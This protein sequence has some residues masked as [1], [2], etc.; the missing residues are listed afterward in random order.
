MPKERLDSLLVARGL[1]ENRSRAQ[2]IIMAGEVTVNGSLL[3][4]AGCLVTAD[5][6][7]CL[8]QKMPYVSR[9]GL[10]LEHALKEFGIS[11]SGLACLDVGAS[12]GGFTDCLLQHGAERVYALDVGHGQIDYRLRQNSRVTVMEKVNA[13]Y[14]FEL[15]GKVDL[16]TM[17]VS[18]ISVTMVLPNVLPHLGP[19]GEVVVLFKPQF[20]ADRKDV[21]KGG[22]IR[23]PAVHA[24]CIGKFI[25]WMNT[26]NWSLLNLT[27]S[28]VTGADGNREF[29]MHMRPFKP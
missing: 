10:K 12:T 28:P 9:G 18:F 29:L 16:A 1:A 8:K 7:I 4:K 22:V 20:E 19:D 2:A 6:E 5:A 3:T 15:P 26:N 13:H 11:V 17:D 14:P 25:T 24:G 27:A 21:G 23:D